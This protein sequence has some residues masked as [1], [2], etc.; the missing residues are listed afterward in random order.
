M[1]GKNVYMLTDQEVF[2]ITQA[3]RGLSMDFIEK[4]KDACMEQIH[5]GEDWKQLAESYLAD[6]LGFL[7]L[8]NRIIRQKAARERDAKRTATE[9]EI[10][11][12]EQVETYMKMVVDELKKA[13]Q[14]NGGR[15]EL[16]VIK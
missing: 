8:H 9:S 2:R 7:R 11:S 15:P 14:E 4:M 16:H 1:E 13:A 6:I 12:A 5:G 10:N 3:L